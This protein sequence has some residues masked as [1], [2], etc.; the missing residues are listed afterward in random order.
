MSELV[1]LLRLGCI[2]DWQ[3]Q[4]VYHAIAESMSDNT[5]DTIILCQPATPYLCLGYHQSFDAV[6][7]R[8]ECERR[9][10]PVLRRQ[11][12]G[13]A[14]YLDS[15][16]IF[17]QCVFHRRH[18]PP[19]FSAVFAKMLQAPV[20]VLQRLGLNAVLREVNE[21]EVDGKRIA[22]TGGGQIGE[23][24]VVVGNLLLDFDYETMAHVLKIPW[25]SSRP[26]ILSAMR[27]SV[28]TLRQ[29]NTSTDASILGEMLVEEYSNAF[30]RSLEPGA[31]TAN[32]IQLASVIGERLRSTE[33]LNLREDAPPK[34]LKISAHVSI[35]FEQIERDG[36]T[37]RATLVVRDGVIENALLESDSPQ[38]WRAQ[39]RLRGA[40]LEDWQ[41]Y[42]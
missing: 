7:D 35:R 9:H 38:S 3:T 1:R 22:G 4:A 28:T 31:L 18:V 20:A 5:P 23:A 19:I 39:A 2:P 11:V 34:P 26:L 37:I 33:F 27:G 6:L 40:P 41:N 25:E 16:Q 8:A 21:I 12:G 36:Q 32:E 10:L 24:C 42:F 17:Y 30:K 15:N 29:S 14:T 13:G